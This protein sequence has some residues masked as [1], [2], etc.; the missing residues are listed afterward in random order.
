MDLHEPYEHELQSE[1]KDMN[2]VCTRVKKSFDTKP[3]HRDLSFKVENEGCAFIAGLLDNNIANVDY[4]FYN[5][6]SLRSVAVGG[7]RLAGKKHARF[8][9]G[10]IRFYYYG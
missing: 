2:K 1:M 4:P 3:G 10:S 6:L 5:R 8:Y 9:Q 7:W